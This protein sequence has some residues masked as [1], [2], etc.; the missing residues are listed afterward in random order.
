[1]SNTL[2]SELLEAREV[3][4]EAYVHYD[5][6]DDLEAGAQV[7]KKKTKRKMIIGII[8]WLAFWP[9][10]QEGGAII[11]T[12]ISLAYIGVL[13]AFI[14]YIRNNSKADEMTEQAAKE[15]EV[16]RSIIDRN[17]EKLTFLPR[18]YWYP[19]AVEYM[20]KVV[21]AGRASDR[22]QALAMCD[23]QI[24]RWNL[25]AQNEAMREEMAMQSGTLRGI[26]RAATAS[27]VANLM[28]TISK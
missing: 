13:I 12:L 27:A 5:R 19:A 23:E 8:A 9:V 1:M 21:Q 11:G 25:E 17:E 6:A 15:T 24:H 14:K 22:N 20:I 26:D 4:K 3:V 10:L 18:D 16:A 28:N 2:L 7:E